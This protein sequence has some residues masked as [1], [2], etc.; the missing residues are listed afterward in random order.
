MLRKIYIFVCIACTTAAI[1]RC[2]YEYWQN[3]DI[4][5]IKFHQFNQ[6]KEGVAPSISL[7]FRNM[8]IEKELENFGDGINAV[9]Y[10]SFLQGKTMDDRM[11]KIDYD[12]VTLDIN[13]YLDRIKFITSLGHVHAFD[14]YT[15]RCTQKDI[16]SK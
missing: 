7:C 10:R 4:S 15:I 3:H 2:I 1:V 14:S 13:D 12:N 5:R 8:F 9:S 16:N 6:N 11:T